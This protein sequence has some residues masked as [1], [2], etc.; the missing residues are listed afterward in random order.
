MHCCAFEQSIEEITGRTTKPI[1][2]YSLHD[3]L[4][5]I[6]TITVQQNG[7]N[8]L[9]SPPEFPACPIF[10]ISKSRLYPVMMQLN[11]TQKNQPT[12][13]QTGE[14]RKSSTSLKLH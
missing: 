11:E 14:R 6:D 13:E 2:S 3:R 8:I 4:I 9:N 1:C 12:S 7:P 5:D 10:S